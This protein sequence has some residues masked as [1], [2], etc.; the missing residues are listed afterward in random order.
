MK[1][2]LCSILLIA[3]LTAFRAQAQ[4]A[5]GTLIGFLAKQGL[6]GAARSDQ[7]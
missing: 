3:T 7:I 6:A 1:K 5:R 4:Q 2:L